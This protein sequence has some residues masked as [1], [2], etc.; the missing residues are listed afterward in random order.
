M[1][2]H[3]FRSNCIVFWSTAVMQKL[4][5]SVAQMSCPLILETLIDISK[6]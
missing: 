2:E 4:K 3:S 6:N 1:K 5:V